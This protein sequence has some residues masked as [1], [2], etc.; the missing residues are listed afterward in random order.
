MNSNV[1]FETAV[2]TPPYLDGQGNQVLT[3]WF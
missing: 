2:V 1:K 3:D